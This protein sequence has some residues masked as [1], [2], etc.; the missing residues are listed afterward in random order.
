ML[1]RSG[2]PG[3]YMGGARV[4]GFSLTRTLFLEIGANVRGGGEGKRRVETGVDKLGG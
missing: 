1:R 2:I 4:A 3:V